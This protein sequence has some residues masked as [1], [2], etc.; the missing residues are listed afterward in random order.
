MFTPLK[1]RLWICRDMILLQIWYIFFDKLLNITEPQILFLLNNYLWDRKFR[2]YFRMPVYL[3]IMDDMATNYKT[4][5]LSLWF[6]SLMI[7]SG[8]SFPSAFLVVV[9]LWPCG[10]MGSE[11]PQCVGFCGARK[12]HHK[13]INRS[14]CNLRSVKFHTL[15]FFPTIKLIS[16]LQWENTIPILKRTNFLFLGPYQFG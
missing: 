10:Q 3:G 12:L 5:S 7:P 4:Q 16:S 11:P 13:K 9:C 6:Q 15:S 8:S 2:F 14:T 1:L